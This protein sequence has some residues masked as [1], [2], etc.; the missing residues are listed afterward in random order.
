[1]L[2]YLKISGWHKPFYKI[3]ITRN[4]VAKRHGMAP[5]LGFGIEFLNQ[6]T[7]NLYQAFLLEQKMLSRL[8]KPLSLRADIDLME[9]IRLSR[10]G[11]SEVFETPL[12]KEAL[13]YF[14]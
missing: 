12:N 2:Y 7:V 1:M 11:T 10:I 8:E 5:S 4:T 6:R 9:R 14:D 13:T 3:G